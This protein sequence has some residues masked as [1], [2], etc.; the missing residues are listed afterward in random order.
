MPYVR[1]KLQARKTNK[2]VAN[3]TVLALRNAFTLFLI[4][5]M[6]SHFSRPSECSH[7]VLTPWNALILFLPIGMLSHCSHPSECSHTV[8][9]L[10]DALTLFLPLGMFSHWSRLSAPNKIVFLNALFL[11][12]WSTRVI[13]GCS[14]DPLSDL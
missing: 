8:L 3:A 14:C 12:T 1:T 9:V 11:W 6:L 5:G 10:R 4:L 2:P 13:S 7:T